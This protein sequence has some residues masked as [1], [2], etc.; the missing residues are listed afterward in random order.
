[1]RFS[2][3]PAYHLL[4]L[5]SLSLF[6]SIHAHAQKTIHRIYLIGDA[7]EPDFATNG[8]TEYLT[9]VHNPSISST[10]FFLGDNIYPKG[11][12]PPGHPHRLEA[13]KILNQQVNLATSLRSPAYFIPGNHD[14]KKGGLD[15]WNRVQYQQAWIDSLHNPLI[16]MLPK[17]GCPGPEEVVLSGNLAVIILDSQWFLHPWDKPQG[18]EN[19][20]EIKKPMDVAAK[21]EELLKRNSDKRVIVLAHHPIFTYGEHGGVFSLRDHLFPLR[22]VNKHWW[23]P[24]PGI[25]SIYPV[26]RKLFGNIQDVNHPLSKQYRKAVAEILEAYPGTIYANGHEHTLQYSVKDSV[27]YITS[28]S[29]SKKTFVRKKGYAHYAAS[30]I[31]FVTLDVLENGTTHVQF[32]EVAKKAPAHSVLITKGKPKESEATQNSTTLNDQYVTVPASARYEKGRGKLLGNNYRDEWKQPVR[33]PVFSISKESGGLRII[34]KG[35]GMQTLSLRLADSTGSEYTLRSVEKYP[36]KAVPEMLRGTFAQDLVQ[37]QISAAHPYGA[38]AVPLLAKA[39][40]IYYT[41][42]K[43]VYIPDDPA[44]GQYQKEFANTLA[45]FE[46]RPSGNAS[47][48]PNFG[49]STKI[50]STDKVLEKLQ[51]DNDYRIDQEF[52][53]RSR[54][55]D[56][57]IGD[58]D[59]HDDQWRWASFD[60]KKGKLYRPIPRDRDQAFFT[61]DGLLSK[62]WSRPWALPKFE[63]FH[64]QVRWTPGFMFNARHFDRSFLHELSYQQWLEEASKLK[65]SLTDESIDQAIRDLPPEIYALHGEKITSIIKAR[66]DRLEEYAAEHYRFLSREVN[67]PGSDKREWFS[68]HSE[69]DGTLTLQVKELSKKGEQGKEI[70]Q[71]SFSPGVT[72]ELRLFGRGGDDVFELSGGAHAKIKVRIIGGDG[73]DS[74]I[75][76]SHIRANVYDVYDGMR[77]ST[78][79]KLKTQFSSNPAVNEFDRKAFQY[80]RLAPLLYGNFNFDDGLFVGGGF[81]RTQHGF[82]KKPYKSQHV[83]LASHALLT[84]S[85][86]FTYK[87]NFNQ[88]LNQWGLEVKADLKAPNFVN[89]FFGWGNETVFNNELDDNPSLDLERSIDYYRLRTQQLEAQVLFTR[90]VGSYGYFKAGPTYQQ[91]EIER[92]KAA[93][94]F[95]V[96]EFAP[97][98]TQPFFEETKYFTGAIFQLGVNQVDDKV[99]PARGIRAEIQSAVMKGT[100]I[101]SHDFT[102]Q[103]AFVSFY[104]SFRLPARLTFAFRA[105]GGFNTG[106]YDIYNAQILDGKTELR[107]YRKTRFYG[108]SRLFFNHEVRLK[109]LSFKSYLFPASLGINGFFDTGRVWYKDETGKDPSTAD[110]T[111][112]IWHKGVGGGVWFTPFSL[113]VVSTEFAHS[114]DGNMLYLRLGF[115]F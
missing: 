101:R 37:D 69:K 8:L 33:V 103:Q 49:N 75:Q 21:L 22:S 81:L 55:F 71:R 18:D 72:H 106:R 4:L 110:G 102:S 92:P 1:M 11:M 108:D 31:G 70:Y 54:L 24:L 73:A 66:R 67:V 5:L 15:G 57:A 105:G 35:G 89:N 10:V 94:R 62:F 112:G 114:Q 56:L 50:V 23:I 44:L 3:Q 77:M 52:V 87:G 19:F 60:E 107:G 65:S 97:T 99:I 90:T 39:A 59:R 95:I 109:L 20:C 28:G 83:F 45:I 13:E 9:G 78:H 14:W 53:L 98:Q 80:P 48:S 96:S 74:V 6:F 88:V 68:L 63:G 111:S 41:Q 86:N 79:R 30:E 29:G 25:G 84:E 32:H 26:C 93:N 16:Q 82:R 76:Q 43:L 64:E 36:E 113:T 91:A 42:P 17:N 38:L 27:H 85:Y 2:L 7:G 40:G 58:W 61:S 47:A 115:L 51:E 104:Q 100:T 12:P 34:Q 46:E